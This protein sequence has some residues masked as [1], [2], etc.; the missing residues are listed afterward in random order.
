MLSQP[1]LLD[2]IC[3]IQE[4]G[5][6]GILRLEKSGEVIRIHFHKGLID[7]A[8]STIAQFQLGRLLV[9]K[10][11]AGDPAVGRLLEE[12]RRRHVQLGRTAVSR[13]VLDDADL[14]VVV[15]EQIVEVVAH[16]LD[17]GFEIQSFTEKPT[18]FFRPARLNPDRLLLELARHNLHPFQ[19]DPDKL[20]RLTTT[21]TT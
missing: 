13:K 9:R 4:S 10:G 6:T 18:D 2:K 19:V 11:I 21:G 16:A 17:H 14:E 12:S 5:G 20:I 3:S 8:G 7:A 15:R 1:N